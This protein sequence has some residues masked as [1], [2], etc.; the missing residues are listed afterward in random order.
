M[1]PNKLQGNAALPTGASGGIGAAIA[2]EL[3][4][5]AATIDRTT[6]LATLPSMA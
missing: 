5:H 1:P 3:A 4:D 2:A 6:R